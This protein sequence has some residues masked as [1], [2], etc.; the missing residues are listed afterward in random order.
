[1]PLYPLV[2][3][4]RD[5]ESLLA[6]KRRLEKLTTERQLDDH[7]HQLQQIIASVQ[8]STANNGFEDKITVC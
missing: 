8:Q 6:T 7:Q 1:M 3:F 2:D 4:V 5:Y